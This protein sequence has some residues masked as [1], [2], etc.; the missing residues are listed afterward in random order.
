MVHMDPIIGS[1]TDHIEN[2]YIYIVLSIV[3]NYCITA[4]SYLFL[5]LTWIQI[6]HMDPYGTHGSIWYTWIHMAPMDRYGAHGSIWSTWTY[7]GYIAPYGAHGCIR[8]TW[9]HMVHMDPITGSL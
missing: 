3:I 4:S 5:R 7:M 6:V 1:Y 8:R 9:I 2:V